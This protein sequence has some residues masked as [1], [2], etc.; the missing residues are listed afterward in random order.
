[1][2]ETSKSYSFEKNSLLIFALFMVANV[3]NFLFQIAMGRALT[4][5]EYGTENALFSFVNIITIGSAVM[6]IAASK[7]AAENEAE[8]NHEVYKYIRQAYKRL[9]LLIILVVTIIGIVSVFFLKK[10]WKVDASLLI[11][12]ILMALSTQLPAVIRGVLQ[13]RELFLA[14]GF[15]N[16]IYS[17]SRLTFSYLLVILGMGIYG[18]EAGF[19]LANLFT[20]IYCLI[21]VN[22]N[23]TAIENEKSSDVASDSEI[24]ANKVFFDSFLI[25]LCV[26]VLANADL[27]LAKSFLDGESAGLYASAAN[28]ARIAFYVSTAITSAM[29]PVIVRQKKNHE[30]TMQLLLKALLYGAIITILTTL[31]LIIVGRPIF[32]MLFGTKYAGALEYLPFA[33]YYI[34]PVCLL[35]I[36]SNYVMAIGKKTF[37]LGS[38]LA[39][40]I[41]AYAFVHFSFGNAG[42]LFGG[43][44]VILLIDVIINVAYSALEERRNI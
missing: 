17:V 8:N 41:L 16:I 32:E 38:F 21:V 18:L 3:F 28:L 24:Y 43:I 9:T 4:V 35:T 13:G 25:Y 33:G 14:Y 44:G 26:I 11:I 27:L 5:E 39:T 15:Q 20:F 36:Y 29:F 40:L 30:S 23:K 34:V 1:M 10:S 42:R 2:K 7:L 19:L 12:M 31:G 37:F 6:T 22:R